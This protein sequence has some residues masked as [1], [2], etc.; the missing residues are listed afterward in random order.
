MPTLTDAQW[1]SIAKRSPDDIPA[2]MAFLHCPAAQAI[3]ERISQALAVPLECTTAIP[4]HDG[5]L[6]S[7]RLLQHFRQTDG[8]VALVDGEALRYASQSENTW[9]RMAAHLGARRLARALARRVQRSQLEVVLDLAGPD[10]LQF[11]R[12]PLLDDPLVLDDT[13]EWSNEQ[14][15]ACL[16]PGGLACLQRSFEALPPALAWRGRLRLPAPPDTENHTVPPAEVL[17]PI[18]LALAKELNSSWFS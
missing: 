9:R 6:W 15:A 12:R 11:A 8:K 17:W 18:C 4:A 3:P 16:M 2:L 5:V 14:I 13:Q 10:A 1:Q 7:R